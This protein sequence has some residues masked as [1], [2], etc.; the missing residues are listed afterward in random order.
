[1]VE[2]RENHGI[3]RVSKQHHVLTVEVGFG[4]PGIFLE[5]SFQVGPASGQILTRVRAF[6]E[7]L[8]R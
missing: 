8:P 5:G 2:A 7:M 4:T 3:S 6:I 1:L